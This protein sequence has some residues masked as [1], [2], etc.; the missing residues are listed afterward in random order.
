MESGNAPPHL[1]WE[2]FPARGAA[3][4][5]GTPLPACPTVPHRGM[6]V[7]RKP[8][9]LTVVA[10]GWPGMCRWLLVCLF[11]VKAAGSCREEPGSTRPGIACDL[12][13]TSCGSLQ[14]PGCTGVPGPGT[15]LQGTLIP[16]LCPSWAQGTH[17]SL[18]WD[19]GPWPAPTW[20]PQKAL[21]KGRAGA[22]SG[23]RDSFVARRFGAQLLKCEARS[24]P[25]RPPSY[26]K[27]D[28][29]RGAG[30]VGAG[31]LCSW[32]QQ[33]EGGRGGFQS[34]LRHLGPA[35]LNLQE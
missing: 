15:L 6:G 23:A 20:G 35:S 33:E 9:A 12:I 13:A 16:A 10:R 4:L 2:Q 24:L 5:Q 34:I 17:W 18:S 29:G 30:Q 14:H 25:P 31:S 22:S 21:G 3:S 32:G 7:N 11:G 26:S 27:A 28:A 1:P 19:G 8:C